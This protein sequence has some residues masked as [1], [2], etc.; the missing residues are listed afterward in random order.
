MTKRKRTPGKKPGRAKKAPPVE[1]QAPP[2]PP[3]EPPRRPLDPAAFEDFCTHIALGHS[4]RKWAE[5]EH[6]SPAAIVKWIQGDPERL[7]AYREARKLQ[8]DAH[9]DQLI[10]LADQ[11]VPK[12]EFGNTD[13]GA[14][15]D[16]R[17]RIDTRKWIAS[18][19]HPAMYADK[20]GVDVTA[21]LGA[22]P[23]DKIME[24]VI[25]LFATHGLKVVPDQPAEGDHQS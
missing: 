10:E 16:K 14:V 24:R 2:E 15:N 12:N 23:P 1:T 6:Y 18:K 17:L 3:P 8:A 5:Q 25:E 9:I 7:K 13:S 4:L 11:P 22:L 19:Y 21:N 20:V